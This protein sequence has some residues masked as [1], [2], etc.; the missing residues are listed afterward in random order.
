MA[1]SMAWS[2]AP[3]TGERMGK[4]DYELISHLRAKEKNGEDSF[5]AVGRYETDFPVKLAACADAAAAEALLGDWL[6]HR[7]AALARVQQ[8]FR[9]AWK[10]AAAS[11]EAAP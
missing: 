2:S 11:A 6:E 10:A 1:Q 3:A 4:P 9:D 5:M 8:E 7:V